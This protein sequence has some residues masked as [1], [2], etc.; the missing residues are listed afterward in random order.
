MRGW[1]LVGLVLV[2]VAVVCPQACWAAGPV[3]ACAWRPGGQQLAMAR[4][5]SVLCVDGKSRQTLATLE[6]AENALNALA[7]SPAGDRLVAAEGTPG[8]EGALRVWTITPGGTAEGDSV[9]WVGQDD[10]LYGVAFTPDGKTLVSGG[11]DRLLMTWDATSGKTRQSLVHH[12]APVF[13]VSIS[14]DG[15]FV[16]SVAGDSTLKVWSLATAQRLATFTESTRTLSAV[17]FSPKG[18]EIVAAGEDRSLRVWGWTGTGGKLRRSAFAHEGAILAV[19]Y[20]PDGATIYSAGDDQQ[21]KAWD[22][23]TLRERHVYADLGDWPQCLAVS[24]D[25]AQLAIGLHS[26]KTVLVDA[27]SPQRLGEVVALGVFPQVAPLPQALLL[28]ALAGQ[29]PAPVAAPRPAQ[30]RLDAIS[31]RFVVRGQKATLTF[32]GANLWNATGIALSPELPLTLLAGDEKQ[33]NVRRAEVT[34]PADHAPG[35]ALSARVTTAEGTTATKSI[36]VLAF[37]E[38][39]EQPK[40]VD[41]GTKATAA[42]TRQPV[43]L[44]ATLRG[45][46]LS[47]GDVDEWALDL[48]AGQELSLQLLGPALGSSLGPVLSLQDDQGLVVATT[49]RLVKGELLLGYK[50]ARAGRYLLTV[51]DRNFTGGGNHFYALQVG[52]FPLVM[53][54][55]ARGVRASEGPAPAEGE[56]VELRA[57]GWNLGGEVVVPRSGALGVRSESVVTP[58]G[59]SFNRVDYAVSAVAELRESGENDM[60]AGAQAVPVPG[61]VSGRIETAGDIDQFA[62]EAKRGERLTLEVFAGRWGSRLDS[63]LEI[64]TPEGRPLERATLRCVGETYTVLRDHDSKVQGIRLQAWDDF[65][66]HDY[67][68]AGGEL[69]KIRILPLGPDED[70]KFFER[71]G[72]RLGYLG[73]TPQ[74]HA[75]S[76]TVYKVEVHPPGSQ[77]PPNGMPLVP[78]VWS[79]D[80]ADR[81]VGGDSRILFDVPAD[82]RYLVR[83]RDVRGETSDSHDY[84][85]V[86]RP[87]AEGFRLSVSPENPVIPRG[88]SALV[89]VTAERLDGFAGAIDVVASGLPA[90]VTALPA[91]IDSEAHTTTL[92]LNAAA[93]A[94]AVSAESNPSIEGTGV[95]STGVGETGAALTARVVPPF[96]R[97][98]LTVT[99]PPDLAVVVTPAQVEIRPGQ[100]VRFTATI[101]RRGDL[102]AR[103]PVEVLNL[104]LG[105]RVLDVGLNGVLINE[106]ET[107]REFVVVCDP[108]APAGD[109]TIYAAARIEAR[110]NERH[111]SPPVTIRVVRE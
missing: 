57:T 25:G 76:S 3:R 64:L 85:L 97:L 45:T 36:H 40:P 91:R 104:P 81:D 58:N 54:L 78:L 5:T 102:K 67:L 18:D 80:D 15:Q 48:A 111:A 72:Q 1:G 107:S 84:R 98:P 71:G 10:S 28:T 7:W 30:P 2:A 38:V 100:E 73:T 27:R 105:L 66:V 11:Y 12:T 103:I 4:G 46:I 29:A 89:T 21:V 79:N 9:E 8:V 62:F 14:P 61:A 51:A 96:G 88:G 110:G 31:P 17:A 94:P 65:R 6:G 39:V 49:R 68:L 60:P 86:I 75:L 53:D 43:M 87:R 20:S 82:G 77:F 44:P 24:P 42:P 93:D 70:T 19:A 63:L 32:S 92:V 69:V 83:L 99:A 106:Q 34:L 55:S 52:S 56:V 109:Q 90:G 41:A 37:P 50:A 74:A 33:P 95:G 22:A 13:G 108:W 23:G 59:P 35:S 47:K 16:A 101:E 26:G